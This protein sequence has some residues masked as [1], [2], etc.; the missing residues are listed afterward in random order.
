M[1]DGNGKPLREHLTYSPPKPQQQY[2]FAFY[3]MYYANENQLLN[4]SGSLSL[5]R[6]R[7]HLYRRPLLYTFHRLCMG[8]ALLAVKKVE[9][10]VI[11]WMFSTMSGILKGNSL[12]H[13]VLRETNPFQQVF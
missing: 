4:R 10:E 12:F 3:S 11:I 6:K 2:H 9:R 8:Y 1:A 13:L 5:P 7:Q